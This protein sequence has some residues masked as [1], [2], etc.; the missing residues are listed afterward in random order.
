MGISARKE[1]VGK[2]Q[3][4]AYL[5][6]QIKENISFPGNTMIALENGEIG[7]TPTGLFP[8]RNSNVIQGMFVKK[9]E[10]KEN[11]W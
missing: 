8:V 2:E 11:V 3:G 5:I 1:L 10:K 6:Q 7:F 9:G 4:A